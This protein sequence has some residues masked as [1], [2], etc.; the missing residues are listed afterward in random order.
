MANTLK[1]ILSD[2]G[3]KQLTNEDA[4]NVD[5]IGLV[6]SNS[7][8]KNTLKS[9]INYRVFTQNHDIFTNKIYFS[10]YFKDT[11]YFSEYSVL[12]RSNVMNNLNI[13]YDVVKK[14]GKKS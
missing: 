4:K 6:F 2:R 12:N 8:I 10:E 7:N 13:L 11:N 5:K 14:E 1:T 3:W 9:Q